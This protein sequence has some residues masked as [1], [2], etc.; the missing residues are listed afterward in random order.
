LTAELRTLF[1]RL[2]LAVVTVTHDQAEAFTLADRV[3]L[4]RAGRVVQSGTPAEVWQRPADAF[5]ARFLGFA[6]VLAVS[7]D[8]GA[9]ATPWGP[10]A[11]E[12]PDGPAALVIR[13]D[14][15]RLVAEG[16][17]ASGLSG[18]PTFKGDHFLVPVVLES[19]ELVE[20]TVRDAV[21]ADGD[22]VSVALDRGATVF[23]DL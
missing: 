14:G 23:A 16:A 15:L 3:V 13:P 10:V 21:P 4:L 20:V 12:R 19:G 17:A 18:P 8:S 7:V 11:A 2:G 6:N 9:A 22:R 5:V 1:V